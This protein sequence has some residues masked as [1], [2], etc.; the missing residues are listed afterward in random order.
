M[1]K[2]RVPGELR[3]TRAPGPDA[4]VP[5][6]VSLSADAHNATGLIEVG[7]AFQALL[8]SCLGLIVVREWLVD[9]RET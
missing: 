4:P 3:D 1:T 5:W 8:Q 2:A 7:S 9:H 6:G